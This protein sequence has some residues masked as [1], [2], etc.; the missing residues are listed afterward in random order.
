MKGWSTAT[1]AAGD[2][3]PDGVGEEDEGEGQ[4]RVEEEVDEEARKGGEGKHETVEREE[5]GRGVGHGLGELEE[6]LDFG[7]PVE[8]EG[9]DE[10]HE[11]EMR[12]EELE[13][14]GELGLLGVDGVEGDPE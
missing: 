5:L 10:G 4:E 12:E 1:G 14:Y 8:G 3:G 13:E 6:G 11:L 2:A 7:R 9:G